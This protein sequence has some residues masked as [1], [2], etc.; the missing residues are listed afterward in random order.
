MIELLGQLEV[1]E[2]VEAAHGEVVDESEAVDGEG[3]GG[4]DV[5][6]GGGDGLC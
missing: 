6:H 2:H 3:H 1:E 4:G 5:G